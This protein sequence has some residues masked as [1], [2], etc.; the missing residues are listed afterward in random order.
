[1]HKIDKKQDNLATETTHNIKYD[2]IYVL[3][4]SATNEIQVPRL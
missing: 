3:C 2:R 4:C 1:M